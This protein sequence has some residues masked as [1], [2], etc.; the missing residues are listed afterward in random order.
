[1]F[2]RHETRPTHFFI[3]MIM[4][5]VGRFFALFD[6]WEVVQW[7]IWGIAAANTFFLVYAAVK[8]HELEVIREEHDHLAEISK[9][10]ASKSKTT[11]VIE[12]TDLTGYVHKNFA[13]VEIAPVKIKRFAQ[14][15]LNEGRKM[16]IREWTPLKKGKTFSDGEWRR[17]IAFMKAPDWEDK[18]IRFIVPVNPNN[19]QDGYELTAAGRK[20]LQ[21]VLDEQ[22]LTPAS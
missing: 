20:W 22:V 11:L 2:D 5:I 4:V 3:P 19:E 10:D 9:L 1:M 12:K 13:S 16:T 7:M 21:D 18:R 14:G 8:K 6:G 15:V 17:L